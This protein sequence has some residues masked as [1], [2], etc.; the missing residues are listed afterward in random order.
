M[1][2]PVAI[3]WIVIMFGFALWAGVP[4]V[5]GSGSLPILEL[6]KVRSLFMVRAPISGVLA[7]ASTLFA[8]YTLSGS[9]SAWTT[10]RQPGWDT[11]Q[12]ETLKLPLL[13]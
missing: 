9:P 8:F 7:T 5:P 10:G 11:A 12:T 6:A 3:S 1:F 2:G 4:Y 13:I